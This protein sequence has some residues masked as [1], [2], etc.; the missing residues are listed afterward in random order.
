MTRKVLK[1]IWPPL[2]WALLLFL[3]SS[4]PGDELPEFQ[5]PFGLD[6][7]VHLFLYMV[8]GSLAL[9]AW[10]VRRIA[11]W[12]I[13]VFCVGYG[14]TDELHQFFVPGR[15]PDV[16]DWAA[17]SVGALI[18]VYGTWIWLAKRSSSSG[19]KIG[20]RENV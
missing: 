9:R 11:P 16:W 1:K 12:I 13:F 8:L 15:I 18:G 5:A 10:S 4:I 17:D 14:I 7:V 6:K 20:G 2:V 19:E 3:A